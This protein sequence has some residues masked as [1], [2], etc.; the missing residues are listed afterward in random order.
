MLTVLGE[1]SDTPAPNMLDGL[2]G[3]EF[4]DLL[5]TALWTRQT[6]LPSG[7]ASQPGG[8]GR[9]LDTASAASTE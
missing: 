2:S 4:A 3:P 5:D 1:L 6:Q 7:P 9:P 8:L